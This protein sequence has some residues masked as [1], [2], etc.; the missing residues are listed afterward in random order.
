V[1]T[2]EKCQKSEGR[3]AGS[4]RAEEAEDGAFLDLE[5]DAV[6]AGYGAEALGEALGFYRVGHGTEGARDG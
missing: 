2:K 4:V 3:L 6:D 1:A 5:V